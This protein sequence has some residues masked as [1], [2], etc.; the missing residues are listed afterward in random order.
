MS[1]PQAALADASSIPLWLDSSDRPPP[2]PALDGEQTCDLAVVGGGYSGLWTAL[3]AKQADPS[4]SVVL[5]EAETIAW[6]A[7]G[8]NGGFCE[9]SLTHG[10]AN[11]RSRFPGEYDELKRLGEQNLAELQDTVETYGVACGLEPTGALSVATEA[12]QVEE[13]RAAAERGDGRFLDRDEVRAEVMSP[14][15]LA[16]LWSPDA[17]LVDPAKLAWGLAETAESLG[18]ALHERSLV[19]DLRQRTGAVEVVTRTGTLTA[20]RVALGTNAFPSLVRR[21]RPFVVPVYDYALATEPLSPQQLASVGWQHRQGV[22]DSANQFHYYRLTADNRV[23]FGG[24]D[25]IYHFRRKIA[26]SLDQRRDT[27]ELCRAT[28]STPSRSSRASGS[29]TP[30]AGR[31]TCAAG[32]ARSSVRRTGDGSPIQRASPVSASAPRVSVLP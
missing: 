21:V 24:Y 20:A 22:G 13:L 2:R 19:T 8:R 29:P 26:P 23:V 31:S 32:S 25:A 5:L 27:F 1:D 11:G 6:A 9:A 4:R 15:Y 3:L 28:S 14:T 10:P 30:G 17:V 18:V 16:G 12:Y 7:S